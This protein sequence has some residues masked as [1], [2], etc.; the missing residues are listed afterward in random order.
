VS[1]RASIGALAG[2]V[3]LL[4]GCGSSGGSKIQPPMLSK[5]V[6]QSDNLPRAFAQIYAGKQVRA[7]QGPLRQD[8]QRFHRSGGWI[9]RYRRSGSPTTK[10]PL[11]IASRA[12]LFGDA[13]DANRDL[14]LYRRDLAGSSQAP[15]VKLPSLGQEAVGVTQ[16]HGSGAFTVRSYSIAWREANATA[17]LE[18]NG[19]EGGLSLADV[20]ALA[21]KQDARMR[22]AAS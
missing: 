8:T 22:S 7:D 2:V 12:D 17:E 6:L 21:R 11:V 14:E 1:S 4:S 15:S 20:V 3:F 16:K 18:V 10:G 5:L 19:F 9:A 13:G